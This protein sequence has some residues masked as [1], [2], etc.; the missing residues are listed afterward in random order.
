[1]TISAEQ[2]A[3]LRSIRQLV[4]FW[5]IS[6]QELA[7]DSAVA[8]PVEQAEPPS[9]PKYRHPKSGET[10]DGVGPQPQWLKDAL[11]RE[12]YLVEELRLPV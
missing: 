1:M 7:S 12:G 4:D 11:I 9:A 8:P 6:A 2:Q 10:W 5:Q 3:V